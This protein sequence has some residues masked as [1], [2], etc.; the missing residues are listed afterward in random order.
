MPLLLKNDL[1]LFGDF[2]FLN[3]RFNFFILTTGAGQE[4]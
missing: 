1:Y 4:S 2:I 3:Y